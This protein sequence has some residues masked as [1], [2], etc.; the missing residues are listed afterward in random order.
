MSTEAPSERVA[1]SAIMQAV[2]ASPERTVSVPDGWRQ[3]RAM[4]GGLAAALCV[5]AAI[6]DIADLPPLRSAQFLFVGPAT[7]SVRM[8]ATQLRRGKSAVI[9]RA[10]MSDATGTLVHAHLCFGNARRS[11]IEYDDLT[12]PDVKPPDEYR[13]LAPPPRAGAPVFFQNFEMRVAGKS[14][15]FSGADDPDFLTWMRFREE[16]DRKSDIAPSVALVGIGDAPPSSGV[17]M[18]KTPSPISTIAWSLDVLTD[19]P[20]TQDGF[21]LVRRQ[22][23]FARDG[24]ST[25]TLTVWN[26]AREPMMI[27]R[28]NVALFG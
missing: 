1:F 18:L 2:G 15:P 14:M 3:G 26:S 9:V 4:F 25:E 22:L 11:T 24:Y 13:I 16:A 19:E 20:S 10:E 27:G 21:W 28:Q 7:E 6:E 23:D 5:Q 8:S 17:L 12:A